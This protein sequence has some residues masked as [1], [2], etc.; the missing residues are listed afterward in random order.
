MRR[1][2]TLMTLRNDSTIRQYRPQVGKL[3]KMALWDDYTSRGIAPWAWLRVIGIDDS[4]VTVRHATHPSEPSQ[5]TEQY[6]IPLY[7]VAPPI[8]WEPRYTI[9]CKPAEVEKVLGWF[10]R[11]VVNR[12]NH[13]LGS[14]RGCVWQPM[15][16]AGTP[17]WAY[18]EMTD[19]IAAEDCARLLRVVKVETEEIG[20]FGP[21][22]NCELCKGTGRDSV[23][24]IAEVRGVTVESIKVEELHV[25]GYSDGTFDCR[26]GTYMR[27]LGRSK[28]AK[29]IKEMER[30]GWTVRYVPYAGGFWER[31]RETVVHEWQS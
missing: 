5:D 25:T 19:S 31:Q 2:E 7:V 12:A 29:V 1:E 16:N 24:R 13:D 6:T 23:A 8:G 10:A 30:D 9:Y 21:N 28:R 20:S 22:V 17:H 18:P 27:D 15:D 26:C 11:G 14:S 3:I 4:T